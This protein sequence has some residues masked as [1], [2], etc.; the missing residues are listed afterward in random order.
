MIINLFYRDS[1]QL[2]MFIELLHP[3]SI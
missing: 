2:I 1:N 3:K